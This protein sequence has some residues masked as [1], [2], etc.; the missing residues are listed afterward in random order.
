MPVAHNPHNIA[1]LLPFKPKALTVA[2]CMV[3]L[4][5]SQTGLAQLVL[6]HQ[7]A[8][9]VAP[10]KATKPVINFAIPAQSADEAIIAFANQAELTVVFHLIK[11]GIFLQT[12]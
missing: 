9:V 10:V 1:I 12:K 7:Q 6:P 3:S 2:C 5:I 4:G 8:T 11:C